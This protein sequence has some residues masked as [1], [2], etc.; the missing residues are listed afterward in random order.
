[1]SAVPSEPI[2]IL[3][4]FGVMDRGGAEMRTLELYRALDRRRYVFEFCSLSGLHGELDDEIVALGGAVHMV[5]L[6]SGF[7]LRFLRLL[8]NRRFTAV[9]SH[10]HLFTGVILALSGLAGVRKRI[11]HFRSTADG[12]G[13]GLWRRSRN[14]L[15]QCLL[16][17]SATDIVGVSQAALEMVLGPSWRNDPRCQLIYS[18]VAVETFQVAADPVA[19]RKE[20]GFPAETKLVIHVGRLSPEKNHARLVRIFLCLAELVPG[21]SLLIVGKRDAAIESTLASIV[22]NH[23]AGRNIVFAGLRADIGRLLASSDLMIFPSLREGLPGSVV[24]ASAA[25]IPV[26]A[27]DIPGISELVG[28]LPG[29]Q[30]ISLAC[31]DQY[32]ANS[33]LDALAGR[34]SGPGARQD[35][36]SHF[37]VV[38]ARALF[39]QL[40]NR[41]RENQGI[42]ANV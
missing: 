16:N 3:H 25:G 40:Y 2:R 28:L 10:V 24:E 20:F 1:M 34:S 22:Q 35:F 8:R 6:D 18:G 26:L 41:N 4:I 7:A 42:A 31:A 17:H 29:L 27:S 15:L 19:V 39:E 9:H 30:A 21:A 33:A 5:K 37:D 32:W 14:M 23:P 12:K 36:P 13:T 38:H 11:A